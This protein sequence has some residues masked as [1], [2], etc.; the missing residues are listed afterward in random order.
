MIIIHPKGNI[1]KASYPKLSSTYMLKVQSQKVVLIQYYK[2]NHCV[3][4]N[5]MHAAIS[6]IQP[7]KT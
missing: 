4:K 3:E 6:Q 5:I 2:F 7:H 1:S